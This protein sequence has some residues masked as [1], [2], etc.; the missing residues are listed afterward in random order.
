VWTEYCSSSEACDNRFVFALAIQTPFHS[1]MV[2][3][4]DYPC[5][6]VLIPFLSVM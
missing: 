5:S 2:E 6:A 3:S 4:Q 1:C